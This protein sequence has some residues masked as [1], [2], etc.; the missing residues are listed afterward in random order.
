MFQNFCVRITTSALLLTGSAVLLGCSSSER[1][2]SPTA[3]SA[4]DT[5]A[6]QAAPP[7]ADTESA[8]GMKIFIDP[9]TGEVRDPT[10]AERAAMER[11]RQDGNLQTSEPRKQ[12]ESKLKSGRG[13]AITLEGDPETPMKACTNADGT[14]VIG[15]DCEPAKQPQQNK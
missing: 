13:T 8:S 12:T 9:K 10:D 5:P 14:V 15:H 7:A 11:A 2:A 1:Q 6:A 4:S 3:D